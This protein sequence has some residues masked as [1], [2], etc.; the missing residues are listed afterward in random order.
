MLPPECASRSCLRQR[1]GWV[2]PVI[3]AQAPAIRLRAFGSLSLL[4]IVN[5]QSTLTKQPILLTI[6]SSIISQY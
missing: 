4:S 6:L 5:L 1:I 2:C 3:Q